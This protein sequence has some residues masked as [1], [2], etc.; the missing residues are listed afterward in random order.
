MKPLFLK[1]QGRTISLETHKTLFIGRLGHG[2][3]LEID[4]SS[5]SRQHGAIKY[6]PE[7]AFIKDLES[8]N[9]IVVNG[10]KIAPLTWVK[11]TPGDKVKVVSEFLEV[12]TE[13]EDSQ[14]ELPEDLSLESSEGKSF[15]STVLKKGG[16]TIGRLTSCDLILNDPTVS[17]EHAKLIVEDGGI[18]IEDLGSTNKTYL[19]GQ[20]LETK[21]LLKDS[22]LLTISFFTLNLLEGLRDLR[23]QSVAIK[24][25]SIKKQ[26][27]NNKIGLQ[28]LSLEIPGATFVAMMGPSGC[29]KSTL[30]KCLNGDN[31]ATS[32]QVFIHGL[33]LDSHFNLIKRKIG[34]VPQ[35]DI[36]HQQLTV[37]RTLYYAAKLRLP[38]DTSDDEINRRIDKVIASLNLD[39][40]SKKDIR[41]IAVGD[42]SGGQR[43]RIS[44]AVELLT[45]PTIL[46]LDEPTSPLDPETI[47]SFL[48][49]L[50]SLTKSGTTIVMVTHKPEDLN[51]VD[52]V[53]FLGVQ[54]HLT[55]KGPA[56]MMSTH[57][58]V[59][60]IVEVYSKM[61]NQQEVLKYYQK[62]QDVA[63][64]VGQYVEIKRDKPDS[65]LLQWYWLA[66][67]Y[68]RIKL[69]DRGNL[70]LL[71]AQ[72]VI[73][74]GL[75]GL[76]FNQLRI[77]VLF[78]MAISAIW[79]GVSNSAK[80]IVGELSV[81]RRE[82]MFNLNIHT[83]ILSKWAILSLIALIQTLVFVT[84]IYGKFKYSVVDEYP[85]TYLH[86]YGESLIFMFYISFSAS[87]IGLFLSSYFN[88]TEKVM[89]VVPIALMP[90]IML[91][92]VMTRIDSLLVEL[93]SFLTLGRWGTEGFARIQDQHFL[94]QGLS[95]DSLQS[96]LVP[97]MIPGGTAEGCDCMATGAMQQLGL[98]DQQ[99]M[100]EGTLIGS[101]FDSFPANLIVI[102]LLNV[103]LYVMIYYSLKKKDSI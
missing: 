54:G 36:I 21:T 69:N 99:L 31:P 32:G 24:A 95:G 93:L 30:L 57:F 88:S 5:V 61:S 65:L 58:E 9:G 49:S 35:D 1:F 3:D 82:R 80:E 63:L 73:I 68:L 19:N 7:G 39:Q 76:V 79:F 89:T 45:E 4:D 20:V 62:P 77:G 13:G 75:V 11:I 28:S 71:L 47:E 37:Y 26:Y 43:K 94:D 44:I 33:A 74:A 29:G 55:F 15:K 56:D 23:E 27:P 40:D 2:A 86:S 16:M 12:H 101:A 22:D 81:Y 46:F 18:W 38:D 85:Q 48:R 51:Y 91:A 102:G 96:V 10:N 70:I 97:R 25:S 53:I 34:Y 72:P 50:Q 83:Y 92:G 59:D 84:I 90:Q 52:Q 78:L 6:A 67:R 8:L 60:N 87:L 17:R 98:Y 103:V 42:L 66:L 41:H 14:R 64:Q 100:D